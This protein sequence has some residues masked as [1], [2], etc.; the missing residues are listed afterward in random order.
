MSTRF[1][2]V[3]F[4]SVNATCTTAYKRVF[5]VHTNDF[6][7]PK[8]V[9]VVTGEL[10][11]MR[12]PRFKS[13]KGCLSRKGKSNLKRSVE[14]LLNLTDSNIMLSG[15]GRDKIGFMT[16]TLPA[17]QITSYHK[18]YIN[19]K[20]T[21]KEIKQKIFNQFMTELRQRFDFMFV[22]VA[23]K[24]LNGNIHFHLLINCYIDYYL[25]RDIWNRCCEKLGYVSD[26]RREMSKLSLFDYVSKYAK[27]DKKNEISDY[28][29]DRLVN[30][31]N[32]GCYV[33]WSEPNSVSIE[34]LKSVRN[35]CAYIVKYMSKGHVSDDK[36]SQEYYFELWKKYGCG[37][38]AVQDLQR[39]DGRMW[40]CSQDISKKR[41]CIICTQDL[42]MANE[43]DTLFSK[44]KETQIYAER[45][46]T[47]VLHSFKSL[48][49]NAKSLFNLYI[50]NLFDKIDYAV[51]FTNSFV[52]APLPSP[53]SVSSFVLSDALNRKN[54]R[55]VE[56]D[57]YKEVQT[58]QIKH[59]DI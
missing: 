7:K 40:Q 36:K 42:N 51:N 41:R 52:V 22:W 29:F 34:S 46:F 14:T 25:I 28:E 54:Y 31:Y 23:E 53:V 35:V 6:L 15:K 26:Y 9:N 43:I 27:R 13:H 48:K 47:A 1:F 11:E 4:A 19:Y 38:F 12:P 18:H 32:H 49:E 3:N 37:E 50:D 30:S 20:H 24:Q 16:L 57:F 33:N 45:G 5:D 21:D 56:M 39:V 59:Y 44:A 58:N 17:T 10:E 55:Q 2:D 8:R